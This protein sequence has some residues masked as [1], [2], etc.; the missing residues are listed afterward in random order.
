MK[1]R[2]D[3]MSL[4]IDTVVEMA[5]QDNAPA[6]YQ[7]IDPA[8]I[9]VFGHSMGG[10]ASVWL[11]RERDDISALVNLDG[12][13]FSEL[14]LNRK[15]DHFIAANEAYTIPLLNIYSDDVWKQLD[16]VTVYAGNKTADHTFS[17]SYSVHF[18]GANHMSLTDLPLFSPILANMMPVGKAVI[19]KYYCIETM[20]QLVLQFLII[21]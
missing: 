10:A 14:R 4:V 19:D 15:A 20:N 9:G 17:E 7:L 8:K 21:H 13:L 5:A 18:Q 2:T 3:D 12:P 16:Y 1:L 11:G 6:V